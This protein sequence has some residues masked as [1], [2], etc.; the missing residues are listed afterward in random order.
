MAVSLITLS[1]LVVTSRSVFRSAT[2]LTAA[3]ASS[4]EF[5]VPGADF[6]AAGQLL[7]YVGGHHDHHAFLI[8]LSQRRWRQW[9]VRPTI[10]LVGRAFSLAIVCSLIVHSARDL[11]RCLFRGRPTPTTAAIGVF[12]WGDVVPFE[13]VIAGSFWRLFAVAGVFRAGQGAFLCCGLSRADAF[14]HRVLASGVS[15]SNDTPRYPRNS[16]VDQI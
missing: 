4:L 6:V 9:I 10:R 5:C 15:R 13:V 16:D 11:P 2:A 7:I 14:R 8:M 1:I 3:L 12:F